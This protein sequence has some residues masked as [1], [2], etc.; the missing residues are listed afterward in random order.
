MSRG[1][2]LDTDIAS[3]EVRIRPE[4]RLGQWLFAQPEDQLFLSAITIGELRKGITLLPEGKHRTTLERW[5]E[6]DLKPRFFDRVLPVTQA[7]AD[8][9]GAL[10]GKR[11]LSGRPINMP[12][13]LIAATAL[14][15][16]LTLV[17]RNTRDFASLQLNLLNPWEI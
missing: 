16:D 17:T 8:Q 11:Q 1:F 7:I 5:L 14:G 6:D 3:E 9:W 12:D 10:D 2:L 13:G 4:T 15:H